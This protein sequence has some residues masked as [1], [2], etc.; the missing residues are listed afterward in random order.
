MNLFL[1]S[2][3]ILWGL[4]IVQLIALFA[5]YNHFGEMYL[6]SREGRT[7]QG[8]SI[9][10]RIETVQAEDLTGAIVHV[11]LSSTDSIIV[12]VSTACKP[13]NALRGRLE[14]YAQPHD[15]PGLTLVCAGS[16]TA[17]RKWAAPLPASIRV[18]ADPTR[19]IATKYRIAITPYYI[20]VDAS[21][22]LR[23]KGIVNDLKGLQFAADMLVSPAG[24][25]RVD[26]G[27]SSTSR[28]PV[29][30]DIL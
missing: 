21:G 20:G 23:T 27:D 30:V 26:W 12:F 1:V 10:S 14:T 28:R 13:C 29:P 18:V 6:S 8:P 17:V 3:V 2:Y 16:K 9:G 19:R 25:I 7:G 11:P 15:G 4:C 24:R 5:L 22:I